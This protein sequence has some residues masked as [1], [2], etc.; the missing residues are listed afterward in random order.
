MN[1]LFSNDKRGQ[2][3]DSWYAATATPLDPFPT[4]KGEI[5][6]DACVV[7]AGYTGLSTALHLAEKGYSVVVLEAQRVGFGASGRNGGQVGH[8]HN[9][10]QPSLEKKLGKSDARLLWDIAEESIKITRDLAAK[11]APDA[12]FKPG[13]ASAYFSQK[14][15]DTGRRGYEYLAANYDFE[16]EYLDR[17]ATADIIGTDQYYGMAETTPD[18]APGETPAEMKIEIAG[19]STAGRGRPAAWEVASIVNNLE[20]RQGRLFD[21][22]G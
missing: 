8:G 20:M 19:P 22:D 1:L 18:E 5:T 12:L 21:A 13:H 10:D 11:H 15:A 17:S 7:G 2:Y 3:P 16:A 9:M 14:E 6:A 4:L